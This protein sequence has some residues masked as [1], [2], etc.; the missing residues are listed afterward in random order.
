MAIRDG[1]SGRVEH[2]VIFPMAVEHMMEMHLA[3]VPEEDGS[4]HLLGI[5]MDISARKESE[6][7]VLR[8]AYFDRL[9]ALPNRSLLELVLDQEIP[10]AH[11]AG[12]GVALICIDLDL[13]SRVNN[14]MGHSAGDAVLRQVAQRLRRIDG[15]P[16]TQGLLERLSLTM[17]ISGDWR[18]GL[19]GAWVRI[20]SVCC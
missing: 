4:R 17:E 9:T 15:S 10:R 13:F 1:D 5:S 12:F 16:S 7:E 8:L 19:A 18:E 2:R 6:R 3:V 20:R 11:R 14:A